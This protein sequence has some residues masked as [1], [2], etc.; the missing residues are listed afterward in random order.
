MKLIV[1]ENI[2]LPVYTIG[3]FRVRGIMNPYIFNSYKELISKKELETNFPGQIEEGLNLV[4]F[5]D[6]IEYN[7]YKVT[8]AFQGICKFIKNS[9]NPNFPY[10]YRFT[11]E[12]LV[13]VSNPTVSDFINEM[14]DLK[15][16][17]THSN[18]KKIL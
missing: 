11:L 16:A 10:T 17:V 14:D 4:I 15:F 6:D 1:K 2:Y 8:H 7:Y 5:L 3:W 13:K 9:G 18:R 12:Y